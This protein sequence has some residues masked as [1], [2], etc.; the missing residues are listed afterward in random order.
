MEQ[1]PLDISLRAGF[2]HKGLESSEAVCTMMDTK[3]KL[4][5]FTRSITYPKWSRV[6]GIMSSIW[7]RI[8]KVMPGL[9]CGLCGYPTC[10]SFTRALLVREP[11]A[12]ACP[13]L[14]LPDYAG[15][16]EELKDL[17]ESWHPVENLAPERPEEGIVLSKPCSDA[18]HL[19]MADL[20]IFNGIETGQPMRFNTLDSGVMCDLL[21]CVTRKVENFKCSR[22]LS[23]AWGDFEEIKLHVLKDGRVRMRRAPGREHALRVFAR[24]ER[25]VIGAAICDCCG[26]DLLSV[27]VGLSPRGE[28]DHTVMR[29]GSSLRIVKSGEVS[30]WAEALNRQHETLTDAITSLRNGGHP[31]GE[32]TSLV[33]EILDTMIRDLAPEIETTTLRVLA[34]AYFVEDALHAIDAIREILEGDSAAKSELDRMVDQI[35]SGTFDMQ[36]QRSPGNSSLILSAY[37]NRINRAMSVLAGLRE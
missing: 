10:A 9:N 23:Y 33:C 28:R 24:I 20:C 29:A 8:E 16:T 5:E 35:E 17:V 11:T 25:L 31:E 15:R 2:P 21:K 3:G 6:V 19:L 13:I 32:K 30:D 12:T 34:S 26:Y 1:H 7:T 18:S 14:S 36:S 37:A 27:A 22:G 4:Q